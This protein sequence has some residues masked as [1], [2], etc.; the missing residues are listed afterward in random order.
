MRTV[1]QKPAPT[2]PPA[3]G[4][5]GVGRA[6]FMFGGSSGDPSRS[7]KSIKN[8]RYYTVC[9]I[10]I[11]AAEACRVDSLIR[12]LKRRHF[13][14]R[15]PD[16]IELH[17]GT[18]KRELGAYTRDGH[19][20]AK[21]FC[22]IHGPIVELVC[23]MDAMVNMVVV[24]KEPA[25]GA[26]RHMWVEHRAWNAAASLFGEAMGASRGPAVGMAVLDEYDPA[27][28]ATVRQA[29]SQALEP[30]A[31][32]ATKGHAV[33]IPCPVFAT[34]S[35]S[36]MIQLADMVAYMAARSCR[37]GGDRRFA[38]WCGLARRRFS[39]VVWLEVGQG[40]RTA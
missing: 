28:C 29:V 10:T 30:F 4:A 32:G 39:N 27:T 40:W 24:G 36:S 35:S 12:G 1:A 2:S 11:G 9:T 25:R 21:K 17:G 7:A 16:S 20:A 14:S 15:H 34:S 26:G 8:G 37:L 3:E 18:L 22:D 38:R 5:Q 33:A 6:V 13:S 19:E 31:L 23:G